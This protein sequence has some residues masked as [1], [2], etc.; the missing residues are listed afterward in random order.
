MP[1]P[2]DPRVS[3]SIP[4]TLPYEPMARPR[5]SQSPEGRLTS[6]GRT[7]EDHADLLC[8]RGLAA[9]LPRLEGLDARLKTLQLGVEGLDLILDYSHLVLW[10]VN[11]CGGRKGAGTVVSIA[12]LLGG[13]HGKLLKQRIGS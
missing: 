13:T 11:G 6:A 9:G 3:I 10:V 2:T 4:F 1:L 7:D 12:S 5:V 8:C